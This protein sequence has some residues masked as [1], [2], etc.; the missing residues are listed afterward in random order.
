MPKGSFVVMKTGSH[1]MRTKL[2]LFL[3]WG[4]WFGEPLQMPNSGTR[5]VY[6]AGRRELERA[7]LCAY[8]PMRTAGATVTSAI[9]ER[10]MPHL[11]TPA[12]LNLE[13]E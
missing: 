10:P 3:D 4:I 12:K 9:T 2:K 6:Y 5:P 1:P 7:I 11:V 13:D 8:P